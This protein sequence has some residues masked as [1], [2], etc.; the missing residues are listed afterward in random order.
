VANLETLD[1]AGLHELVDRLQLEIQGIHDGIAK[2]YFPS[3]DGANRPLLAARAGEPA[4]SQSS[5]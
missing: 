5:R 3:R 1:Q 4:Q 2:S